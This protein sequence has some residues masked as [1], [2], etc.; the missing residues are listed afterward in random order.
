MLQTLSELKPLIQPTEVFE[1]DKIASCMSESREQYNPPT[2]ILHFEM[3]SDLLS[4]LL[5]SPPP[6]RPLS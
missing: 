5:Y 2:G 3:I 6:R 1:F 4:S